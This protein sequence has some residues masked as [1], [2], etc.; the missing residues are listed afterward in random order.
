MS[1]KRTLAGREIY[2][3]GFG[4]MNVSHCY[5]PR[6][7]DE[8]GGRVLLAALD[9]GYTHFDTAA[10]YGNGHNEGLIGTY[11]S[12]RRDEMV[13]T[14]KCGI[15]KD[16]D[17][18]KRGINNRPDLIRRSIEETLGL[19]KTDHLDMFYLHRWDKVTPIEDVVGAM[20][21]LVEEGKV[22]TLGLSETGADTLRKAHATHPIAAVQSEYSLWTRNPEI[23]VLEECRKIGAA[24]VAFSPVARQFLTGKRPEPVGFCETDIRNTM[25]RFEP[26]TYAENMKLFA[27]YKAIADEVGCTPAQLALAWLLTRG[28]HVIPIPGTQ[29]LDHLEENFRAAEVSLTPDVVVRLDALINEKTVKGGR[30]NPTIQAQ[31]DTEEFA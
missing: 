29:S 3:I 2:P 25:P 21:R 22:R 6:L 16:P 12:H 26:E 19:L 27:P 7:P 28:E 9:L 10:V 17:T 4:A 5:Q 31:I 14:S 1:A 30:Y 18:G 23:A 13:L 8:E 20:G 11:L 24:F 15:V